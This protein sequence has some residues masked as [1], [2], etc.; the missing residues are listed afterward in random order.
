[1]REKLLQKTVRL[2]LALDLT[3]K[4]LGDR[5]RVAENAHSKLWIIQDILDRQPDRDDR[6]L[7]VLTTPQ[8]EMTVRF[9]LYFPAPLIEP[10]P[11]Y[12]PALHAED[13]QKEEIPG[14]KSPQVLSR[15]RSLV[16]L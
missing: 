12:I 8:I 7:V 15:L 1:M 2:K 9:P 4:S 14:A 3:K 5:P 13:E 6:A 11:V 16:P 10:V